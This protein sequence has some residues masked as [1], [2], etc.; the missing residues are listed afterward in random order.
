M[1]KAGVSLQ[2]EQLP[3]FGMTRGLLLALRYRGSDG[4]SSRLQVRF[5]S[6]SDCQSVVTAFERRGLCFQEHRPVTARPSTARP[7]TSEGSD[8]LLT[9][10]AASRHIKPAPTE[11]L[12]GSCR[13]SSPTH[14]ARQSHASASLGTT[15]PS[16]KTV[17]PPLISRDE[18]NAPREVVPSR[19]ST[20]QIYRSSTTPAHRPFEEVQD[21]LRRPS[22]PMGE[23]PSS[24]SHVAM[25]EAIREDVERF[26]PSP[27]RSPTMVQLPR[28]PLH[29][30]TAN[31]SHASP[32]PEPSE[33][34]ASTSASRYETL[35][36]EIPPRRDFFPFKRPE[37]Q[38]S[39]TGPIVSRPT[40]SALTMLPLP[41]PSLV[42]S[43]PASAHR[44][45]SGPPAAEKLSSRPSTASPLKRGYSAMVDDADV[46]STD[47]SRP[48]AEPV[49]TAKSS[50]PLARV[51]EDLEASSRRPSR[52]NELLYGRKALADRSA[53]TA[54]IPRMGSL[55]DAPHELV[56]PPPTSPARKL[57]TNTVKTRP[58]I[59]RNDFAVEARAQASSA[60]AQ[61]VSLGEYAVQSLQDRQAALDTFMMENLE[62]PAFTKLCEDVEGCWRRIALGL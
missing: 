25:L 58:S 20:A 30:S 6:A 26:D 19:P 14:D 43:R 2:L 60:T 28:L 54:K 3:I 33:L 32:V 38:H 49:A 48:N 44:I 15:H 51:H 7:A 50:S 35:E 41:K 55:T 46:M 39:V 16:E 21:I 61:E 59:S 1:E 62:N 37:S 18:V 8:R 24:T 13:T 52:M 10:D 29:S 11:S 9:A 17:L 27:I 36:H 34:R 5:E 31:L 4:V 42:K 53:N 47:A 22:D 56:S 12:Q 45:D 57:A 23:R 40:S